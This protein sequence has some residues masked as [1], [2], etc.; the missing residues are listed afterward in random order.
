MATTNGTSR[1]AEKLDVGLEKLEVKYIQNCSNV[2]ELEKILKILRSGEEGIY[3]HLE[4][5]CESKLVELA[6]KSRLLRKETKLVTTSESEDKN[7]IID[8]LKAWTAEIKSRDASTSGKGSE[9]FPPVRAN[10]ELSGSAKIKDE[11][12]SSK[13]RPVPRDHKEW[14]RIVQNLNEEDDQPSESAKQSVSSPPKKVSQSLSNQVNTT[15]MTDEERVTLANRE[16]DKGNEA[17]RSGDLIEAIAYYNRSLSVLPVT[18]TYNN[19]ALAYVRMSK[20]SDAIADC[21]R[22]LADEAENVKALLRRA[23]AYK[24]L[25]KFRPAKD[26]LEVVLNIEPINKRAKDMLREVS[27]NLEDQDKLKAQGKGNRMVIEET[28]GESEEE[29]EEIKI[30]VAAAPT[31]TSPLQSTAV[32]ETKKENSVRRIPIVEESDSESSDGSNS[33]RDTSDSL[34]SASD[35]PQED[36][37]PPCASLADLESAPGK[38][39]LSDIID[40]GASRSTADEDQLT[41]DS[42]ALESD[43]S[44]AVPT[45]TAHPE[46]ADLTSVYTVKPGSEATF[47]EPLPDSYTE[48]SSTGSIMHT[49]GT[50]PSVKEG[51]TENQVVLVPRLPEKAELLKSTG[52]DLFKAGR[53]GEASGYYTQALN[54][55]IGDSTLV[56]H[57]AVLHSNRA[58]CQIKT[59]DCRAAVNDTTT[60]LELIP[61][62][63]KALLRRATAQEMLERYRDAYLDYRHVINIDP[64]AVTA[65]A[66]ASRCEKMLLSTEGNKWRSTLPKI[67]SSSHLPVYEVEKAPEDHLVDGSTP[68][69]PTPTSSINVPLAEAIQVAESNDEK[70]QRLKEAGNQY[71]KTDYAKAISYYTEAIDIFSDRVAPYSNRALCYLKSDKPELAVKD[72]DTVLAMDPGHIKALFRRA[73]ANK[74]LSKY[75]ESLADLVNLLKKEP[76]NKAASKEMADVKLAY[77]KHLESIQ[78]LSAAK[79][80]LSSQPNVATSA[81]KTS[82]SEAAKGSKPSQPKEAKDSSTIKANTR[83]KVKSPRSM[84]GKQPKNVE[85]EVSR[86]STKVTEVKPASSS[87]KKPVRIHI[88]EGSDSDTESSPRI[89]AS[90]SVPTAA[91]QKQ[92]K[93]K[94][95]QK[96]KQAA[97]KAASEV[98]TSQSE[99]PILS[100]SP[101]P[102]EF[103][104]A[105][106]SMRHIKDTAA[107]A[108]LL[109]QIPPSSLGSV[110]SNKLEADMLEILVICMDNHFTTDE[111]ET[112]EQYLKSLSSVPRLAMVS[113]LVSQN[114]KSALESLFKKV[115]V[116]SSQVDKLRIAFGF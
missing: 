57:Q 111:L 10:V 98:K 19:R 43:T 97:K 21:N 83:T 17:F 114:C 101:T 34:R 68:Q 87:S 22:V 94:S 73:Q 45:L 65:Y 99:V 60:A 79:K 64:N 24:S 100:A 20:W 86:E 36:N 18:A 56:Y 8:D 115:E 109:R 88:E 1:L 103:T 85:S 25:R 33:P 40:T 38:R 71:S 91:P 5:Q 63:T 113:M 6:P 54:L 51:L 90:S 95:R 112:V 93:N 80:S 72:C 3:P 89:G 39:S 102:Y 53:Y 12:P 48:T 81:S 92:G 67:P 30:P 31:P 104:Q 105:W 9:E 2:K 66:G 29:A 37:N 23:C 49:P 15:G 42:A 41:L 84:A 106:T 35:S 4:K 47:V 62:N 74:E 55:I 28:D 44:A 70:F 76:N 50:E 61:S 46:A 108:Q 96:K 69:A 78:Q 59:G 82:Q 107:Y 7:A 27:K 75:K 16:K 11:V 14:D 52:N 58:A 77:K 32:P 13:K 116:I 26:D 110:I